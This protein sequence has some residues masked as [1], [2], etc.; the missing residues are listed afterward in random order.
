LA[1]SKSN[2]IDSL[3]KHNNVELA[4]LNNKFRQTAKSKGPERGLFLGRDS[5]VAISSTAFRP[6]GN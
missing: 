3:F 2:T 6:T 1:A 5:Q 4:E